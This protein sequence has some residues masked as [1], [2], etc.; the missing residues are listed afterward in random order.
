MHRWFRGVNRSAKCYR[1]R[2]KTPLP[3]NLSNL[4]TGKSARFPCN[5]TFSS[6]I[7]FSTFAGCAVPRSSLPRVPEN[8]ASTLNT[9]AVLD[10]VQMVFESDDDW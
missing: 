2:V 4:P 8:L 10:L 3:L 7:P 1:T 6:G 9:L 5:E